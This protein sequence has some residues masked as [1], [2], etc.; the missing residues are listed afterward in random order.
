MAPAITAA[1]AGAFFARASLIDSQR[2]AVPI[3][4][5]Q[6][7]NGGLRP[8]LGIHGGKSETAGASSN[9]VH[10]DIDLI[11]RPMRG[12][13]VSDII[14]GDIKGEIPQVQF[15]AHIDL[16]NLDP[17]VFPRPFPTFGFQIINE[18]KFN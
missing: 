4:A 16:C 11:D 3:L 10:N 18:N 12:K 7:L 14:F 17:L 13:H 8:F 1:A 6:S 15:C 2:A 9:F 5:I